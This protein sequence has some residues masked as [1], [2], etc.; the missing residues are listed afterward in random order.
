LSLLY[1]L[2]A[3]GSVL[4]SHLH[5]WW[6]NADRTNWATSTTPAASRSG[7]TGGGFLRGDRVHAMR[8]PLSSPNGREDRQPTLRTKTRMVAHHRDG[9]WRRSMLA[10]AFVW[11]QFVTVSAD[12]TEIEVMGRMCNVLRLP[13]I[14]PMAPAMSA[15]SVRQ[16]MGFNRDDLP[17]RHRLSSN[18]ELATPFGK[19]S[20]FCSSRR[21]PAR[22]LLLNPGQDGYGSRAFTSF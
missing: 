12:A 5:P 6:W 3:I 22:F 18:G 8:F 13:A 16:P 19:P 17:A 20:R 1:C 10:P 15:T 4:V 9:N 14:C 7:I 2:V 21:R 11:H